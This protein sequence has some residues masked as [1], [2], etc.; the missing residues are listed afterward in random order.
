MKFKFPK[1]S[2]LGLIFEVSIVIMVI[3]V[4]KLMWN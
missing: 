2:A 3:L 1:V 4:I